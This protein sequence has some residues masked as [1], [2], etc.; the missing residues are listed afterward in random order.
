MEGVIW[1]SVGGWRT[2]FS[3]AILSGMEDTGRGW[4]EWETTFRMYIK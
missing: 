2:T 1:V 3:E 4:A